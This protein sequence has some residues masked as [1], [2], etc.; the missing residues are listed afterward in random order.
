M[1][2]PCLEFHDKVIMIR[3]ISICYTV[4]PFSLV[5]FP[6]LKLQPFLMDDEK[7]VLRNHVELNCSLKRQKVELVSL[8]SLLFSF[9]CRVLLR[10]GKRKKV[11]KM[12]SSPTS[13]IFSSRKEGGKEKKLK[14][15][16]TLRNVDPKLFRASYCCQQ[17]NIVSLV[18]G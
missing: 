9:S 8:C 10:N 14:E 11:R 2:S 15:I 3:Q 4:F 7:L 13:M 12:K 6:E 17:K 1:L 5:L 18:F 16:I